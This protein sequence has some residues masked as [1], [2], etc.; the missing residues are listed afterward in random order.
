MRCGA[1][2]DDV[3]TEA[4]HRNGRRKPRVEIVE[5][6]L[7]DHQQRI[8]V[9][10]AHFIAVDRVIGVDRAMHAVVHVHEPRGQAEITRQPCGC[11][12]A[13]VDRFD[14]IVPDHHAASRCIVPRN[15]NM[16]RRF[17]IRRQHDALRVRQRTN[18]DQ[19]R[20]LTRGQEVAVRIDR[21][22]AAIT[23][24]TAWRHVE[25]VDVELRAGFE[26]VD[27]Q[28]SDVHGAAPVGPPLL[29]RRNVRCVRRLSRA[30]CVPARSARAF[31]VAC[32]A[33]RDGSLRLRP[34]SAPRAATAKVP[35]RSQV[36]RVDS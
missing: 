35:P 29:P 22:P 7:R 10:E 27:V 4:D 20:M 12:V 33:L 14:A 8:A 11:G 32:E 30:A 17:A 28:R 2:D 21:Q 25:R 18:A 31:P 15:G 9:G 6:R 34:R 26:R 23:G 36:H 19:P 3:G 1:G 24:R 5:R 13:G 16:D